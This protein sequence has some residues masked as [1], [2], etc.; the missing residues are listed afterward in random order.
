MLRFRDRC[1]IT[2]QPAGSAGER[3]VF[4]T[5]S[6]DADTNREIQID[7][8]ISEVAADTLGNALILGSVGIMRDLNL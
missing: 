2:V 1:S 8:V 3:R 5:V 6:G 4:L 7:L